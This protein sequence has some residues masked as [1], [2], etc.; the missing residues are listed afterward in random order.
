MFIICLVQNVPQTV[1]SSQIDVDVGASNGTMQRISI[2][3]LAYIYIG[4]ILHQYIG[5]DGWTLAPVL[6]R[7]IIYYKTGTGSYVDSRI[8]SNRP[9][10]RNYKPLPIKNP[11]V[12]R[13]AAFKRSLYLQLKH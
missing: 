13:I 1:T 10:A 12:W 2:P 3:V 4:T 11:I 5:L 8:G 6:V 7:S 9:K